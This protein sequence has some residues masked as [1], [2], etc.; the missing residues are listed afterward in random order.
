[1]CAAHSPVDHDAVA[2][3][4]RAM[5]YEFGEWVSRA[6]NGGSGGIAV[7]RDMLLA[8]V[9]ARLLTDDPRLEAR[10]SWAALRSAAEVAAARVRAL[11]SARG[12]TVDVWV[13]YLGTGYTIVLGDP[14]RDDEPDAGSWLTAF[15]LG[16]VSG[17]ERAL[18][19]L[20]D[21]SIRRLPDGP[22]AAYARALADLWV[23]R[24]VRLDGVES[25]ALHALARGDRMA[26]A[27]AL[28]EEFDRHAERF[29]G[30]LAE[31]LPWD[32]L[33]LAALA[34]RRGV[35]VKIDSVHCPSRLVTGAGP[36]NADPGEPVRRPDVG[37]DYAARTL[38]RR[39]RDARGSLERLF[40]PRGPGWLAYEF[41]RFARERVDTF[42]LRSVADPDAN[43][44]RQ[45]TD[46]LLAQQASTAAFALLSAEAGTDV[47]VTVG[48]RAAVLPADGPRGGG[49]G[50]RN[51]VRA[52]GLAM[53]TRSPDAIAVLGSVSDDVIGDGGYGGHHVTEYTRALRAHLAKRSA[54]RELDQALGQGPGPHDEWDCLYLPM[55]RMLDRLLRR[56]RA[57]FDRALAEALDLYRQ[58]HSVAARP[59]RPESLVPIEII[60]MVCRARDRGWDFEV[61][62]DYLPRR[63]VEGA[64]TGAPPNLT[65]YR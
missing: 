46:L 55:A 63:I 64:W 19:R 2:K 16:V 18:A 7:T 41:Q 30:R 5:P 35:T 14:E 44:I 23:K 54:R 39:F 43:E 47:R 51:Y 60:G 13:E 34:R 40:E 8:Y 57:G 17:Q 42:A 22:R 59:D 38:D 21:V 61:E 62:T 26:C 11:E 3:A 58:Y 33:A 29:A 27:T 6:G 56:D 10:D 50:A 1:M 20:V 12:D 9:A 28:R 45:W 49:G 4:L 48:N 15:G 31:L 65:P 37:A 52:V 36:R 25:A 53:A 32:L 24:P